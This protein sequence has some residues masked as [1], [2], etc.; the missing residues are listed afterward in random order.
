MGFAD[1]FPMVVVSPFAG[2][3]ADRFDRLAIAKV[4]QTIAAS[5]AVALTILA[6]TGLI[7]VYILFALTLVSGIDNAF[8]Q[9]V[10]SAMTPNLV[11]RSDVRRHIARTL[12]SNAS[13]TATITRSPAPWPNRSLICFMP[14]ISR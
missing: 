2:V 12:A 3:I 7:N 11:R 14:L 1:L 8:F 6:F 4:V 5:Q 10:R 13:A 9:P